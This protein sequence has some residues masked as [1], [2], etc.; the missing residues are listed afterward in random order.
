LSV[1]LGDIAPDFTATTTQGTICFHDWIG[2]GWAMLMSHP[3]DFTPVCTTELGY[4][5]SIRTEFDRRQVKVISLSVDTLESH[6]RWA[7]DI[8]GTHGFPLN[9]PLI[10]DPTAEIAQLYDMIHAN[11][12]DLLTVRSVF[13]IG[14]DKRVKASMT[15]PVNT[16]RNFDEILRLIDSLQ[17]TGSFDVATPV[18]WRSG[19]DVIIAPTL[20]DAHA[21][22]QFPG[23]WTLLVKP[24]I[25]IVQQPGRDT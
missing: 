1:R 20:S 17:L 13:I 4:V 10:A 22:R 8:E 24:Y 21:R 19:D 9:Y 25:R 12:D 23:G 14:P 3:A 15:Y 11:A 2:D 18:N 7:R 16:G 6:D 5:A